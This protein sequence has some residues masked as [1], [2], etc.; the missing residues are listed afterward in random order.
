[1]PYFPQEL[2]L[3]NNKLIIKLAPRSCFCNGAHGA[4]KKRESIQ[5]IHKS[6]F[7][8]LTALMEEG[9]HVSD[10]LRGVEER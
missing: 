10:M 7:F 2:T 5:F 3:L 9:K 4:N 6:L 1:M 8:L